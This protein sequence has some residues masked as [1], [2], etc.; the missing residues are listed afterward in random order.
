MTVQDAVN[1]TLE[2]SNMKNKG[3]I[4]VL[5]MGKPINIYSMILKILNDSNVELYNENKKNGIKQT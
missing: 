1:L 2:T 4:N 5:N 3:L